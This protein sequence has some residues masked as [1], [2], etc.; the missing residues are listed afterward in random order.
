M[1]K[2][3]N[4]A[5]YAAWKWGGAWSSKYMLMTIPKKRLSVGMGSRRSRTRA[6]PAV[7]LSQRWEAPS[8]A[9]RP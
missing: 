7:H 4:A 9:N 3:A 5:P 8:A 2:A 1:W 6:F